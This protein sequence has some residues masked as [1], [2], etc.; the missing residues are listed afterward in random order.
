MFQGAGIDE[1]MLELRAV[2]AR[3]TLAKPDASRS[4]SREVYAVADME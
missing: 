2:F 3:V 4:G 1:A